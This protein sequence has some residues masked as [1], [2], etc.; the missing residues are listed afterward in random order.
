[1]EGTGIIVSPLIALMNDQV[2]ALK[3]AG[4]NAA[5][6]HSGLEYPVLQRTLNDLRA[7]TLDIVY[8][9]PERLVNDMFLDILDDIKIALFAIDEAHCISQWGHD[10]RPEYRRIKVMID[11]IKKNIPVIALTA[12]ATPKVQSDIVKNL[13]M[14]EPNISVSSFNRDNLYYEVRPKRSKDQ[15]FKE[16]VQYI[17]GGQGKSGIIYVQARKTT[18]EIATRTYTSSKNSLETNR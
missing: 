6:I 9:A 15:T 2:I 10:F 4:V 13:D 12:T 1:M 8:V 14:E 16:I 11:G 3:E 17:K 5:A 18:E 7:G